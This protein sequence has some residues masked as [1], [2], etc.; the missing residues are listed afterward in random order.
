MTVSHRSPATA[1]STYAMCG[2]F[3]P[4]GYAVVDLVSPS[5]KVLTSVIDA[6]KESGSDLIG[7]LMFIG[8]ILIPGDL[9]YPALRQEM[10]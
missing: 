1:M 7:E 5:I 9:A 2:V 3:N 8:V 4:R 6:D 10:C